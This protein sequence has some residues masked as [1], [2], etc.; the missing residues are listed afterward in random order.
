[1]AKGKKKESPAAIEGVEQTLTR[2]EQFLENNWKPITYGLAVIAVVVGIFWLVNRRM[3]KK[4]EEALSQM[5]VAEDYFQIDSL[6]LALYGDGNY[7]GFIDIADEYKLTRPGNLANYYAGLCFLWTG[8][9]EDAIDYLEKFKK[10]DQTISIEAIG[11]IGDAYVELGD[12][13]KGIDYYLRA[14][15]Y[16]ES[17]FYTPLYL[18]KAGQ[19]YELEGRYD[20]AL[21]LYERIKEEYP[22]SSEGGNIDKYIARVK[23][24]QE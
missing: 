12:L 7:L 22:E 23:V 6:N 24:V 11:C 15:D 8:Q 10:R 17:S 21:A 3:D 9:Y 19:L 5:Y 18:L 14:A 16:S 4:S 20:K 2:T 1:M 13:D